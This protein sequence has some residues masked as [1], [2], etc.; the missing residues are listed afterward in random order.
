MQ[1]G[2]NLNQSLIQ[3]NAELQK[4]FQLN[5]LSQSKSAFRQSL[6]NKLEMTDLKSKKSDFAKDKPKKIGSDKSKSDA[7]IAIGMAINSMQVREY[8]TESVTEISE[9]EAVGLPDSINRDSSL[10]FHVL[11]EEVQNVVNLGVSNLTVHEESLG[12]TSVKQDTAF[13]IPTETLQKEDS[14]VESLNSDLSHGQGLKELLDETE[15][16]NIKEEIK[17]DALSKEEKTEVTADTVFE[18]K[19]V[20]HE[21]VKNESSQF[22]D[23]EKLSES[24]SLNVKNAE[25]SK[26]E[27]DS[28]D[29]KD[30][31]LTKNGIIIKP[32]RFDETKAE[33]FEPVDLNADNELRMNLINQISEFFAKEKPNFD[34]GLELILNPA[35]LGK[36]T[37]IAKRA[38]NAVAISIICESAKTHKLLAEQSKQLGTIMEKRLGEPTVINIQD[39]A[40]D[41][42]NRNRQNDEGQQ[43]YQNPNQRQEK[44]NESDSFIARLK[45]GLS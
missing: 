25:V 41:Y 20:K 30:A 27:K 9:P 42:L 43:G 44:Q 45:L 39:K 26:D 28:S 32:L 14:V 21:A 19:K 34:K 13:A 5:M 23:E 3:E 4:I 12:L 37:M 18:E 16:P 8:K 11:N 40:S 22:T 38:A 1:I 17:P 2:S 29:R 15:T 35:S 6:D 36:I 31:L 24:I 7:D 10:K 33:S